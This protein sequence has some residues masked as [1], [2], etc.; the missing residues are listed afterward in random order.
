MEKNLAPLKVKNAADRIADLC[1]E[2]MEKE[3][4]GVV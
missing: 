4:Q 3:K 1:F 2:L